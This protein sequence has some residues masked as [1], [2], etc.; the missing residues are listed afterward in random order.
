VCCNPWYVRVSGRGED[1]EVQISR[2]DE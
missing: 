1:R 2:A